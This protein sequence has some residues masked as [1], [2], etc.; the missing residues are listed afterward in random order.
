MNNYELN[1]IW[2]G[3]KPLPEKQLKNLKKI[4]TNHPDSIINLWVMPNIVNKQINDDKELAAYKVF[5]RDATNLIDKNTSPRTYEIVELL[6]QSTLWSSLGDIL[7]LLILTRDEDNANAKRFYMEADNKYPLNLENIIN[8]RG[9]VYDMAKQDHIRCDSFFIDLSH[10]T[11]IWFKQG[12]R[13]HLERILNDEIVNFGLKKIIEHNVNNENDIIESFGEIPGALLKIVMSRMQ[14]FLKTNGHI[15]FAMTGKYSSRSWK[16]HNITKRLEDGAIS[17]LVKIRV[18][19]LLRDVTNFYEE[20]KINIIIKNP[21]KFINMREYLLDENSMFYYLY[22]YKSESEVDD[23]PIDNYDVS[24]WHRHGWQRK[25]V[26]QQRKGWNKEFHS[27][28]L[29]S[30]R[31]IRR[32]L[33]SDE[34]PTSWSDEDLQ[35]IYLNYEKEHAKRWSPSE[36][37]SASTSDTIKV[38]NWTPLFEN[39][40]QSTELDLKEKEKEKEIEIENSVENDASNVN[41]ITASSLKN[42]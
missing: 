35:S 22:G 20:V 40:K 26:G 4:C 31:L 11:G 32:W 27:E 28:V 41:H 39:H 8:N 19:E 33:Y 34:Y 2:L 16:D 3:S 10:N 5:L 18:T 37:N 30:T 36:K 15:N 13:T 38:R 24:L 6:K 9:F 29:N 17:A 12:V 42:I 1:F 23:L 21:K 25:N 7:K 14:S